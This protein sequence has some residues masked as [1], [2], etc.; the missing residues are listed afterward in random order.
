VDVANGYDFA[1]GDADATDDNG[2]GTMV[3][4][5][6]SASKDNR[7][8]G[9]G[10]APSATILP[11]KVADALGQGTDA[12]LAQGIVWAVDRGA[13]IINLSLSGSDGAL[14]RAA[15]AYALAHD[16]V[17]VA[18]AGNYSLG[19]VSYPAAYSGVIAVGATGRD[20]K[21]AQFSNW[22]PKVDLVAPGTSIM[23]TS[24]DGTVGW[25]DGTSESSP[26][27][28]GAAA[29]LK[30]V[31]PSATPLEISAQLQT[32]AED[33][34]A[35]GWDGRYGSGLVK[36]DPTAGVTFTQGDQ[37]ESDNTSA[38]ATLVEQDRVCDH[39]L[40]PAGD[41][42][43]SSFDATAGVSYWAQTVDLWGGADT[44]MTV[45]GPDG[46]VVA[47]N[48]DVSASDASSLVQWACVTT[49]RY[50]IEV[51]DAASKGGGYGLKV[52][53]ELKDAADVGTGDNTVHTASQ[54]EVGRVYHR[55]YYPMP[56]YDNLSFDVVAGRTYE[57]VTHDFDP[58]VDSEA[59]LYQPLNGGP[60]IDPVWVVQDVD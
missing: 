20:D 22:G 18:A 38:E 47:S 31:E 19:E 23:S 9:A 24:Y 29:L 13:D 10:V 48:D 27:V 56:E 42:D 4:G 52:S 5:I 1:N 46:R 40:S 33:L 49:G 59:W 55:S 3:A 2:H 11:V 16:V 26:F 6:A 32:T 36:A 58:T 43:W 45:Y 25:A 51:R 15:V 21:L 41:V 57:I 60:S 39:A 7:A 14:L 12:S 30:A 28:A 44:S 17:V 35:A 37:W 54:I 8:W 53:F 34:G 50:R